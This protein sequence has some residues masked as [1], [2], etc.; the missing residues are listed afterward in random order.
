VAEERPPLIKHTGQSGDHTIDN[1][2]GRDIIHGINGEVLLRHL[3]GERQSRDAMVDALERVWGRLDQME[4]RARHA[5]RDAA[6]ER[7]IDFEA[8]LKRQYELDRQLTILRRWLAGLTIALFVALI[9]IGWLTV[10]RFAALSVLRFW[11]GGAGAIAW[12]L[13]GRAR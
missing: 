4:H 9:V 2:A 10:D 5:D 13:L 1:A 12:G 7:G 3:D 8:R 11:M 6:M